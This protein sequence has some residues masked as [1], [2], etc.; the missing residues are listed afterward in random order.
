MEP[1]ADPQSLPLETTFYVV[2]YEAVDLTPYE[3]VL[4]QVLDSGETIESL[5]I[6][7][8][9]DTAGLDAESRVQTVRFA[10]L[11]R[12]WFIANG[13]APSA[14]TTVGYGEQDLAVETEDGVDQ[15]LNRRVVIEVVSN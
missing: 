11:V 7:A 10:N 9:N 5:T 1:M 2:D 8:Y 4:R 14:I 12:D 13:V 3:A 6:S 15:Q